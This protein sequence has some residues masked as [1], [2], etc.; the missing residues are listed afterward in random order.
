MQHLPQKIISS[1]AAKQTK[2]C[3]IMQEQ[4]N[5]LQS[6]ERNF[7]FGINY[8]I[9]GHCSRA[10]QSYSYNFQSIIKALGNSKS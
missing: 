3:K 7:W 10:L 8:Q 5:R 4:K 2:S 1:E 6:T 9:K